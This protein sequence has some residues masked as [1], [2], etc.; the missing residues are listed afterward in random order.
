MR[1]SVNKVRSAAKFSR[2]VAKTKGANLDVMR[3]GLRL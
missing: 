2:E 3:G 1:Y